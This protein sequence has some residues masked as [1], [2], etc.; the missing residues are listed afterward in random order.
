MFKWLVDEMAKVKTLKF[1]LVD[2]PLPADKRE[3]V[4]RSE[5]PI[6]PSYKS[7]ILQF[8]NA[9]LYRIGDQYRVQ[10]FAGPSADETEES[11]PRICFGRTEDTVAYF[12]EPLLVPG[13]ESPVFEWHYEDGTEKQTANGFEEWLSKQCTRVRRY[14]TKKEWREIEKGPPPFSDQEKR[15]VEARR[16]FR[17][18]IVGISSSGDIQFE[19]HNGSDMVLPFL[20]IGI[21]GK[22]RGTDAT[23]NGGVWLPVGSVL[24]GQTELIEKGCYKKWVDPHDVVAFEEPDPEP[25]DR[26]RYW[27]FKPLST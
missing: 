12:K 25:E 4:E 23:L 3:L 19:V 20:S 22:R 8:G 27:E 2:G 14:Y 16:K 11:E 7:F 17:W 26:D 24:P 9:K 10:V 13:G 1:F 6:P 18:R 15:I 5:L 21:R